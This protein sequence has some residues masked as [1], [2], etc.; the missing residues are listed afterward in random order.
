ME[1][2]QPTQQQPAKQPKTVRL[3][4]DYGETD[5]NI[6]GDPNRVFDIPIAYYSS[7]VFCPALIGSEPLDRDKVLEARTA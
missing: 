7:P 2:Q 3:K 5:L 6:I 4:Y 1:Q